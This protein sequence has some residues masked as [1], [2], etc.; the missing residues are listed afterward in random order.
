M[1]FSDK[2]VLQRK[3][4][5]LTQQALADEVGITQ[6]SVAAYETGNA[7]AHK[8]TLRKLAEVLHVSYDYL[9]NDDIEDP[10]YGLEKMGYV[11][12]VRDQFGQKAA[13]DLDRILEQSNQLFAGGNLTL[14]GEA[15]DM[16]YQAATKAYI[17]CKQEARKTYG[18]KR[19]KKTP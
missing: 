7:H 14:N 1:K 16:F 5:G 12:Q 18:R 11:D 8:K 9:L 4:N 15:K 17:L 10:S 3:R 2:I 6:R 19:N 13:E